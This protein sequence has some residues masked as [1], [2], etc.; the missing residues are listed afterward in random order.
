ME[1]RVREID[2]SLVT[3]EVERLCISANCNLPEHNLKVIEEAMGKEKSPLGRQILEN[4]LENHRLAREEQV[5]ACQD[6]GLAVVFIEVGQDVHIINGGLEDA[7]NEGVRRGYKNGYLRKSAVF[8]PVLDRKNSGDNTPAIIHAR[9][10]DGDRISI[11]V[12]PKG[13]GAENMSAVAM[14]TPAA[15]AEGVKRFV[16]DTVSKAGPNPCPPIVVGVGIG[17]HG[18]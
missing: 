14:L 2:A 8:D 5:P 12:A 1:H 6:T 18:L 4:L 13:G 3:A 17:G 7:I 9:I 10:V 11:T 15:G 16:I